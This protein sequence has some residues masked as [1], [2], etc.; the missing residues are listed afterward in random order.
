VFYEVERIPCGKEFPVYW[1]IALICALICFV[2]T[3]A[4]AADSPRQRADIVT[5]RSGLARTHLSARYCASSGKSITS[6]DMVTARNRIWHRLQAVAPSHSSVTQS[7][8]RCVHLT[9]NGNMARSAV[10]RMV[11][12]PGS[13]V[14]ADS[15]MTS[16]DPGTS[17]RLLP[18]SGGARLA[19]HPPALRLVFSVWPSRTGIATIGTDTGG[20][21]VVTFGLTRRAASTWC[22]FTKTHIQ[23]FAAIVLDNRVV[24]DPEIMDAICSGPVQI[25]GLS[26]ALQAKVIA[27]YI[28]FG[29][30]PVSFHDVS[31]AQ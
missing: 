24:Q 22:S 31:A 5:P 28:N 12:A 20:R 2:H 10:I 6:R 8:N 19:A 27:A 1:R 18:T 21:P 30:L 29:P 25:V 7:G 17:V 15:G 11:M 13:L 26:S 23:G 3:T 16:L 14:I 4:A 9:V